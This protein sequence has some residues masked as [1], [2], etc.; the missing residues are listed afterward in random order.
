MRSFGISTTLQL[1][2][3]RFLLSRFLISE[4]QMVLRVTKPDVI[5]TCHNVS[6]QFSGTETIS[7]VRNNR[8]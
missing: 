7:L 4:I 8:N 2:Y 3:S 5:N 6:L 1:R